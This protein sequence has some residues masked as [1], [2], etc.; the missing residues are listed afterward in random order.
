M[1]AE[2]E[3]QVP[4]LFLA[5]C[6]AEEVT[7]L[8]AGRQR[9]L[10]DAV[11]LQAR[12]IK[13]LA[14]LL[15]DVQCNRVLG[16]SFPEPVLEYRGQVNRSPFGDQQLVFLQHALDFLRQVLRARVDLEMFPLDLGQA[17]TGTRLLHRRDDP[18]VSLTDHP[19]QGL[20]GVLQALAGLARLQLVQIE[21]HFPDVAHDGL[22]CQGRA[23]LIFEPADA[24][25]IGGQED[26]TVLLEAWLVTPGLQDL[27][28]ALDGQALATATEG[29]IRRQYHEAQS[30]V[31][32]HVAAAREDV[33]T[34]E[35]AA[36]ETFLHPVT[37]GR[38]HILP[39]LEAALALLHLAAQIRARVEPEAVV[40]AVQIMQAV[41]QTAQRILV[42]AD[43]LTGLGDAQRHAL[44]LDAA[45]HRVGR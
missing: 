30:P 38:E 39:V 6:E 14:A 16:V 26:Q 40:A 9:L 41:T 36:G 24:V 23:H 21:L 27:H 35:H 10:E 28:R 1:L 18:L 25:V 4:A 44:Q 15:P 22:P 12:Q 37:D 7:A 5:L 33:D 8:C 32:R 2:R 42:D 19:A 13:L 11:V 34:A 29:S 17:L 31:I 20:I 45:H 3:T 43:L